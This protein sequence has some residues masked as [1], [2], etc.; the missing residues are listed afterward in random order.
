MFSLNFST[1]LRTQ[2]SNFYYFWSTF[3]TSKLI[4]PATYNN[5]LSLRYRF[6]SYSESVLDI[7]AIPLCKVTRFFW[8]YDVRAYST[9]SIENCS[10][11]I[12]LQ[13]SKVALFS[14]SLNETTGPQNLVTNELTL[15]PKLLCSLSPFLLTSLPKNIFFNLTIHKCVKCFDV[16]LPWG[17]KIGFDYFLQDPFQ[18]FLISWI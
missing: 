15:W 6:M 8:T 17:R 5:E 2:S 7:T 13:S 14:R 9:W 16:S 1:Y 18:F 3:S 10:I 11:S 4:Y 12:C